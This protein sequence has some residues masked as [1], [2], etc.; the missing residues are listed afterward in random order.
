MYGVKSPVNLGSA[1]DKPKGICPT[2][3][4]KQF[5]AVNVSVD[6]LQ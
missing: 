5:K 4:L 3:D 6:A 1:P 2:Q